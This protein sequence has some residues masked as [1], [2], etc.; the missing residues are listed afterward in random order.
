MKHKSGIT[1]QEMNVLSCHN[2]A[3]GSVLG[4]NTR[5]LNR[6]QFY[7]SSGR[8]GHQL[9]TLNHLNI[10]SESVDSEVIPEFLTSAPTDDTDASLEDRARSYLDANCAYCHQPG[11]GNRAVF[12]LRMTTELEKQNLVF[13]EL[14]DDLGL[15]DAKGILPHNPEKSMIYH[16]MGLNEP[17]KGMP[18]LA[19]NKV[20]EEGLR[21][22]EE[23]INSMGN[24]EGNPYEISIFPNPVSGEEKLNLHIKSYQTGVVKMEIINLEGKMILT[25]KTELNSL[26]NQ[27]EISLEDLAPGMYVLRLSDGEK[28]KTKRFIVE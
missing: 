3:I 25:Q 9:V 22:I 2:Q 17:G 5:Q 21:L 12:D 24:D 14:L 23:W 27:V 26:N 20:D 11:T 15:M 18:P 1:L 13:G 19:K 4:P 6:Q 7:P 8:M 10:F 28:G 16:R